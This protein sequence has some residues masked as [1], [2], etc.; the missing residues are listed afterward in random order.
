MRHFFP[1]PVSLL[2]KGIVQR[3]EAL[4]TVSPFPLSPVLTVEIT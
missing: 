3:A 1:C 4:G 2:A